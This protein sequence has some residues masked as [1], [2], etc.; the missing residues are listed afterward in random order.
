MRTPVPWDETGVGGITGRDYVETPIA[1]GVT[2]FRVERLQDAS[3]R[4]E[5]VDLT[6]ELASAAGD[7][8]SVH[9]QVRVGGGP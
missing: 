8:V 3:T 5:V 1:E 2:R 4:T 9:T 7:V 6:L